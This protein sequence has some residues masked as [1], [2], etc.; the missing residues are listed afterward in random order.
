MTPP[1]TEP[2]ATGRRSR[3]INRTRSWQLATIGT[4][5]ALST[6]LAVQGMV[7]V[8][9]DLLGWPLP[10]AVLCA[11]FLEVTLVGSALGARYAVL[12]GRPAVADSTAT[13]VLS[14]TS[15]VLAAAHELIARDGDTWTW[16]DDAGSVLAGVVRLVAPLVACWCW[17]RI[18]G[19]D[20]RDVAGRTLTQMKRSRRQ[21]RLARAVV[22]VHRTREDC[23]AGTGTARAVRAAER[24][25]DRAAIAVLRVADA[26]DP[27]LES[28]TQ[29]WI[30]AL[31]NPDRYRYRSRRPSTAAPLPARRAEPVPAPARRLIAHRSA[32]T[33]PG[34]ANDHATDSDVEAVVARVRAAITAGDL[35]AQPSGEAI[36]QHLRI[37]KAPAVAAART[38]K[39]TRRPTDDH[40]GRAAIHA[41]H[42]PP[43]E[44]A[45]NTAGRT[46]PTHITGARDEHT[47]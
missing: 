42:Q 20:R 36:R 9:T 13:W 27:T 14:A 35:P 45:T 7:G 29:A 31:A 44:A 22:A 46:S 25:R 33:S 26:T 12:L 28:E 24:R 17:H 11:G 43:T 3:A 8:F 38:L 4:A 10:A 30:D 19:A 2:T 18:L 15:G 23:A 5:A 40:P 21:L 16:Q 47:P 37:G 34:I 32:T 41:V 6:G 1:T 39:T